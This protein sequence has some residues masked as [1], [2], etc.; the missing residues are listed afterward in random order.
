MRLARAWA[1][2]LA[3]EGQSGLDDDLIAL[4]RSHARSASDPSCQVYEVRSRVLSDSSVFPGDLLTLRLLDEGDTPSV[5]S[6]AAVTIG[7]PPRQLLLLRLFVPPRQLT[8]NTGCLDL[9]PLVL[10][11]HVRIVAAA[12]WTQPPARTA[13]AR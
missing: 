13:P 6:F 4:D 5:V 9:P 7:S 8:I 2:A 11:R 3:A 1:S 10:G 12:P